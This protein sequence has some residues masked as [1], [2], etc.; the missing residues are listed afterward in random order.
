[1]NLPQLHYTGGPGGS[2]FISVTPGVSGALL[3]EAEPLVRYEPPPQ[4]PPAGFPEALSLSVLRDGSRLLARSVRTGSGFHAH[5]VHLPEPAGA[6][7]A[8]GALPITAWG[9]AQWA[10]RSPAGGPP[11]PLERVPAPGPHDRAAL[12][13]FVAARGPWLAGFFADVRRVVEDPDAPRILLVEEDSA[14]VAR[15]VMLACGVLPHERGQWLSFTT[16]ARRPLLAPQRLVGVLPGEEPGR[17]ER[18]RVYGAGGASAAGDCGDLWARTASAVWLAA[19]PELFAQVRRLPA[20]P[21]AAGPL[22]SLALAAG[23]PLEPAAREAAAEWATAEGATAGWTAAGWTAAEEATAGRATAEGAR[24]GRATAEGARAGRATPEGARAEGATTEG[25]TAEGATTEGATAEGATT[26]GATTEGATAGHA[27][28]PPDGVRL[29]ARTPDP[30][31]G[32]GAAVAAGPPEDPAAGASARPGETAPGARAGAGPEGGG[33][34]PLPEVARRLALALLTDP[35]RAYGEQAREALARLPVLRALVLDRLDAL[36]AGDPAAGARLFART[37]L[38]L[39]AAEALPH[40]RMCA[41]AAE[42][43]G[44]RADRVVALDTLLREAGVSLYAEP[45]L[46]RTAMRLVWGGQPPEAEEAGLVLATTG[47]A[48]HRDAGTWELLARAAVRAPAGD[49]AAPDLAAELLRHFAAELPERLRPSLLLLELARDLRAGGPGGDGVRRALELSAL[50]PEPGAREAAYAAVAER[51]LA[52]DGPDGAGLRALAG[53]EDADLLAAYRQAAR[54]GE[55]AERLR[56]S[57]RYLATCF[58]AWSAQPEEQAQAQPQPQASGALWRET[59]TEL[60]EGVLRP[61]VRGLPPDRVAAAGRELARLDGRLAREFRAW[62]RP[63]RSARL[64]AAL[65][66]LSRRAGR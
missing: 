66:A 44:A 10:E 40:L 36:A 33:G 58:A 16:Y 50:S 41:R 52:E 39:T 25:A 63:P 24:A 8:R 31:S 29:P 14:A 57:P 64:R 35:E 55:V 13:A 37:G 9:S 5:A 11:P 60:L 47:A 18:W 6:G 22:A 32:V 12:A 48:V 28:A 15:W 30:A 54:G 19:R 65:L 38:R 27:D 3:R 17:G 53:S 49:T 42:V 43:V 51:L 7:A 56:R 4:A 23:I 20:E 46:L 2:G 21:Y 1:M 61:L 26:E 59:R 62:R 34:A 45:L